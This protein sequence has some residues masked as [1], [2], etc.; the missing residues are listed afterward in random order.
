[1]TSASLLLSASSKDPAT[2]RGVGPL[3]SFA[4]QLGDL[5]IGDGQ[6]IGRPEAVAVYEIVEA[7]RATGG[8]NRTLEPLAEDRGEA[9]GSF[10]HLAS[11]ALRGVVGVD[12]AE[13]DLA[14][15]RQRCLAVDTIGLLVQIDRATPLG[16]LDGDA[17]PGDPGPVTTLLPG[18]QSGKPSRAAWPFSRRERPVVSETQAQE[19]PWNCPDESACCGH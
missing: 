17:D 6:L 2:S 16:Q 4:V 11:R 18:R 1:M 8:R 13:V 7:C 15:V 19:A 14:L 5:R 9:P 10:D 12:V 3:R